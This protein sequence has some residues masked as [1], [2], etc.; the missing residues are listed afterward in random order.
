MSFR[1]KGLS[2]YGMIALSLTLTAL[3]A[4]VSSALV[5]QSRQTVAWLLT[6]PGILLTSSAP[7]AST[8]W[9]L[10]FAAL[11]ICAA[12]IT[13]WSS[14][15]LMVAELAV[16]AYRHGSNIEIHSLMASRALSPLVKPLIRRRIGTVTTVLSLCVAS[17]SMA[18]DIPD[19]LS[20]APPTISSTSAHNDTVT[21]NSQTDTL[22]PAQTL[23]HGS[24]PV[25]PSDRVDAHRYTVRPGDCLWGIAAQQLDTFDAATINTYWRSIYERNREVIGHNPHMIWPGQEL[26]LPERDSL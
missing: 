19:D 11:A 16:H 10:V 3:L 9:N 15:S 1:F 2:H 4:W 6:H 22:H 5:S 23:T 25:P 13:G 12:F 20:W 7:A 8:L 21:S 18:A 24:P 14:A 17:P 26:E